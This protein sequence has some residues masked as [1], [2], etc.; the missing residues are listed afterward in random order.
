MMAYALPMCILAACAVALK[1]WR[2]GVFAAVLI[3]LVQDPLRK[4]TPGTP[5]LYA[6]SSVPVWLSA[7]VGAGLVG[8]IQVR[9]FAAHFPRIG[10]ALTVFAAYLPLPAA[11]SAGFGRNTVAIT[12]LGALIYG[13]MFLMLC[14]G[15]RFAVRLPAIKR[16]LAFYVI[17]ASA[18]LV[19]GPLNYLGWNERFAAIGTEALGH[20]WVTY[21][22]GEAVYMLAGFFRGPD[23]M[24]WHAA[25]VFMVAVILSLRAR[26]P[27][28]IVWIAAAAWGLLNVWLCGRRK[29]VSMAPVFLVV[30]LALGFR[31]H[32]IR[33]WAFAAAML[34]LTLFLGWHVSTTYLKTGAVERFYLTTLQQADV[35]VREHALDSVW[36][37]VRQAGFWGYGLGMG[38]QGIHHIDAELPRLWQESGPSKLFAE[39]GV[40]GALLFL[41]LLAR[42]GLTAYHTLARVAGSDAFPVAAGIFSIIAANLVAGLVSAQIF[43]DPFIAVLLAFLLGV[44]LSTAHRPPIPR[45]PTPCA[46]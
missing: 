38:Q 8:D 22:T 13:A 39:L 17:A 44:L 30:Y 27:A 1:R 29:M 11:I 7:I 37:T 26:G 42:I 36:E 43:G 4:M 15:W 9:A 34:L 28:R 6:M 41:W 14:C 40:P 10:Q 25:T 5:G 12:A 3:G 16:L 20:I 18:L 45:E 46:A 32:G 24:G 19:G 2:W 23:V 33:R 35:S 21:R 31:F